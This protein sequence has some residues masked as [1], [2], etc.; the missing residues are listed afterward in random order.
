MTKKELLVLRREKDKLVRTL[1]G[2][3]EMSKTPS[4]VWIVD[5][6][7]EHIAVGE[8]RKLGIPVIAILDSNCDPDVVDFPIPGNDDAIRAVG[9]LTRVIADAVAEGLVARAGGGTPRLWSRWPSGRPNC[10][11]PT[12]PRPPLRSS[13]WRRWLRPSWLRSSLR[14]LS[15]R[16]SWPRLSLRRRW[17]R[18]SWLRSS[19]RRRWSRRSWLRLSLKRRWP[20]LRPGSSAED[21]ELA[22][23]VAVVDEIIAEEAVVEAAVA[24]AVAEEAVV[25]AA[26]AEAVAEEAVVDAVIADAVAEEAVARPLSSRQSRSRSRLTQLPLEAS[27]TRPLSSH[28]PVQRGSWSHR[29]R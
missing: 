23:E 2:I 7:K 12:R 28:H 5:T 18:P 8:A 3:R 11:P 22:V 27:P 24:E 13:R 26:V 9:L 6:N 14:R 21:A 1:G 15:L 17:S 29:C 20:R 19:L 16:R 10:W 4:A 25:E